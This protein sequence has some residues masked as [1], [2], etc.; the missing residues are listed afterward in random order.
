MPA[1]GEPACARRGARQ[2]G[3]ASAMA[4]RAGI[5]RRLAGLTGREKHDADESAES[6]GRCEPGV[7]ADLRLPAEY[8]LAR[9]QIVTLLI[10]SS[11]A[12]VVSEFSS[13]SLAAGSL[14]WRPHV[15]GDVSRP[16]SRRS[17]PRSR[18]PGAQAIL[19]LAEGGA[20]VPFIA[21]YRK[22]QT[23]NL[24]EVAIRQVLE[25]KERWD[26]LIKRQA[27][28][29][30][31]I[32]R[33]GKLTP[34]LEARIRA[35]FDETLLEDIYLPYKQKRKTKAADGARGGAG[36]ARPTGCGARRTARS[37]PPGRR[38]RR[39][40]PRFVD[41]DK[42]VAD[43]AAALAGAGDIVVERLSE[44][45]A[46]RQR[47]RS[48]LFERGYART[49][50]GEKAKTP[51]RFENYFSYQE[52]VRGAAEARELAPLPG[53][54]PRLDG[55]GAGPVARGR[56][57][58][59]RRHRSADRRA[60]RAVRDGGLPGRR[61]RRSRARRCSS[62]RRA[63]RCAG[64]SRRRSRPRSTRRCARWPTRPP[65]AC[66]PRTSASC[67]WRRPS[68]RSR[69]WAS[70][71]A[72]H[73]L[74]AGRRRR[75]GQA[76]SARASCTSRRPPARRRRRRCSPTW[77]RRAASARSPS[78]TAPP[79][80]RPRPSCARRCGTSSIDVP[81]V[82]VSEAG[83]QR[84]QRQRRRA[85]G[86]PG[87]GRHRARRDLDRAPA[88]GSAGR[89]GEDRSQEHRRRAVPARRVADGAQEEPRRRRRLLREPGRR[90]REH[91][92]VSPARARLRHRARAGAGHRRAPRRRRGCS[93]RATR[94]WR[95]RASRRRR[96]S[97]RRA[98]C[99]C[100]TRRN[101]L[102]NTGVHPERY[103]AL[104]RV[105]AELG[106]S[107]RRSA[108][109][110]REAGQAV[111]VAEGGARR[112]HVRRRRAR[113]GEAGPRS[114]RRLRA[115]LVPR[116][117]P[118]AQGSAAGDGLP[119]HRHQRHQLRRVRRHRRAPGRPGAHLAAR[120][121]VRE[122]SAATW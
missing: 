78:A 72:P 67:C 70:I 62:A 79:A 5:R 18:S 68:A 98:S 57:G 118:R 106:V 47:V 60:G 97:R 56:A 55:G 15:D 53:H 76:T 69:C 7:H 63:W 20:T 10:G 33:Q 107:T 3:G 94:C 87:A 17:T 51:S 58:R 116:R 45:A 71:R 43:A 108:R 83:R 32:G 101:P 109:R 117:H 115:V 100:R 50:K 46:L 29:V 26:A 52:P 4:A 48:A 85:R 36:A 34:E 16:G 91:R 99:A 39:A 102:D 119:R 112:V 2:A 27:F 114:A 66:S 37:T 30:E 11:P 24:D 111:G 14:P 25:A 13:F 12:P 6:C 121:Q 90:Q 59:G 23:G 74:Q 95:C 8:C 64:T 35:T 54:A 86:V 103:A 61:R 19:A 104:E 21:R 113:A 28:I 82:M 84:L 105:A 41:A 120:R 65:S 110:R 1:A 22:E 44:D 96:S 89:A 31:E 88:A 77:S 75:L 81:V 93:S 38:P 49:R 92:L 80:A 40:R 73:R 122:G 9:V 42:G